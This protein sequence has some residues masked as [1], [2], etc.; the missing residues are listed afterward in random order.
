MN[1]FYLFLSLILLFLNCSD[2]KIKE[3]RVSLI[4][5]NSEETINLAFSELKSGVEFG[6]VAKK[7]SSGP[8]IEDGG[9]V[10]YLN[11]ND[12]QSFLMDEILNLEIGDYSGIIQGGNEYYILMKTDERIITVPYNWQ[13][14]FITAIIAVISFMILMLIIKSIKY[15]INIKKYSIILPD[16]SEFM[17]YSEV[18]LSKE[19]AEHY[20]NQGAKIVVFQYCI[21]LIFMTFKRPSNGYFIQ[22]N[23]STLSKAIPYILISLLLGWWGFP[24]G[25][26]Y[27]ISTLFTNFMGG[28]DILK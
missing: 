19:P 25:P 3:I 14:L 22:A 17:V 12:I 8:N 24:W 6:E 5:S 9:D 21:S 15:H 23:E 28:K 20:Y 2:K 18:D 26:I 27:T 10:G 4:I 16:G 11:V 13:R 7:Y 1:K